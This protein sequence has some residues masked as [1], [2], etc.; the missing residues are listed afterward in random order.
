MLARPLPPQLGS[1]SFWSAA[2]HCPALVRFYCR[3]TCVT[4]LHHCQ[5]L[6]THSSL[7]APDYLGTATQLHLPSFC[8]PCH[9][10]G[11]AHPFF[12]RTAH[13]AHRAAP[14]CLTASDAHWIPLGLTH[15][16]PPTTLTCQAP[17]PQ[18]ARSHLCSSAQHI[19]AAGLPTPARG[20]PWGQRR[21][22][23]PFH[24]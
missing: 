1:P 12:A 3:C 24:H 23:A 22:P 14:A 13:A 21:A 6:S 10:F 15:C 5:C 9:P 20:G 7:F 11:T 17:Q 2:L 18:W 19:A 16:E 8:P 4:C